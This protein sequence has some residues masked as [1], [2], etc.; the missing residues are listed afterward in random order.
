MRLGGPGW[1]EDAGLA[2]RRVRPRSARSRSLVG[3][4]LATRVDAAPG[5]WAGVEATEMIGRPRARFVARVNATVL[6]PHPDAPETQAQ[7]SLP[8]QRHQPTPG[9]DDHARRRPAGAT[10]TTAARRTAPASHHPVAVPLHRT[11]DDAKRH[12]QRTGRLGCPVWP[13]VLPRST[14]QRRRDTTDRADPRVIT[15]D[16]AG[17]P[18]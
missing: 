8:G 9:Q 18:R 12:A 1:E 10:T 5:R 13:S 14:T 11:A 17:P 6:L 2:S 16:P 7:R 4:L 3:D 15:A